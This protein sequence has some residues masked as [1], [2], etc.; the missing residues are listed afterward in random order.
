MGLLFNSEGE[1]LRP[2]RL[3][4]ELEVMGFTFRGKFVLTE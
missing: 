1:A 3:V 2:P 4:C